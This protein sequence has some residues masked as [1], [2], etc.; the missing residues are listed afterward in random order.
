MSSGSTTDRHRGDTPLL[1]S[2]MT[3][4]EL[5]RRLGATE[6]T[7]LEWRVRGTGP[8]YLHVGRRVRYSPAVVEAWLA[9]QFHTSTTDDVV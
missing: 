3:P 8:A 2:L 6:R 5:A 1:D 4:A 7:L 9:D